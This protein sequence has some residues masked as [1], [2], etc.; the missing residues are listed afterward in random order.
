VK[1]SRCIALALKLAHGG[2][3]ELFR[4]VDLVEDGLQ[5]ERG[6]GGI[7]TRDAVDAVLTDEDEGVRE[8]VERDGEATSLGAEHEFVLL[9]IVPALG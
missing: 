6:L 5:V 8:H 4:A 3:D 9:Y 7:P 1:L 2:L